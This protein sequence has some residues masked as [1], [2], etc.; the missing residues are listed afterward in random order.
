MPKKNLKCLICINPVNTT[1]K[2]TFLFFSIDNSHCTRS[3]QVTR[4]F[5]DRMWDPKIPTFRRHHY[6]RFPRV[7]A[8]RSVTA[9]VIKIKQE[10]WAIISWLLGILQKACLLR[11][12]RSVEASQ[13][14][15]KTVISH[16]S[17]RNSATGVFTLI[18]FVRYST[19]FAFSQF[20][21]LV[22]GDFNITHPIN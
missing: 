4:I 13:I 21:R 6:T 1:H 15:E 3:L 14:S 10:H 19:F 5:L 8:T 11:S 20:S 22:S 16:W 18:F 2:P 12:F 7:T 17:I 9:H